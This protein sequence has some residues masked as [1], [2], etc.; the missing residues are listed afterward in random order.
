[1]AELHYEISAEEVETRDIAEL[2]LRI[3]ENT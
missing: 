1:M 2:Y 3:Q